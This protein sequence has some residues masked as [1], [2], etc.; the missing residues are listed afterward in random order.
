MAEVWEAYFTCSK[1]YALDNKYIKYVPY[2]AQLLKLR[3]ANQA[4]SM[5]KYASWIYEYIKILYTP[6][7][8]LS[9]HL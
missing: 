7:I 2:L 1:L 9:V 5:G 8:T 6:Q 4:R 3:F